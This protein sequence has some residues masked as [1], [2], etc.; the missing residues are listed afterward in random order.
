MSPARQVVARAGP[1]IRT[2]ALSRAACPRARAARAGPRDADRT[3][4]CVAPRR[5]PP[6]GTPRPAGAGTRP[7]PE[8]PIERRFASRRGGLP[9]EEPL[10]ERV[11]E[12][13]VLLHAVVQV[14]AGREPGCT[15]PADDRALAHALAH[16]HG[17]RGQVV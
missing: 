14:R 5:A 8:L 2:V 4:V 6:G 12:L 10:A 7:G 16:A 15:P 3:P 17:G 9:G 13:A 1:S 11:H